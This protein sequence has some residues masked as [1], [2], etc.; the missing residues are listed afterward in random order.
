MPNIDDVL[1]RE[2]T[3]EQLAAAINPAD[4]VLCLACAGSG[5]S[6]TLAYRIARLLA[7]NEAPEGIVAFTFTEKAAETIKRRVSQSLAQVGISPNVLGAMY[8]GT[9]HSFCQSVLGKIDAVYRQFDVLDENRLK[10]YIISRYGQL[11]L[12]AMRPRARGQSD[13]TIAPSDGGRVP[14]RLPQPR[15]ANKADEEHCSDPLCCR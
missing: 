1:R 12:V 5:K 4:E 13:F 11:G 7:G 14:R 10:L 2:L 8:I 15:G 6:R 9:I 3:P